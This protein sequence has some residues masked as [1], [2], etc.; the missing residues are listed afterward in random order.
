MEKAHQEF[1]RWAA[2]YDDGGLDTRS[3][4]K[5]DEWQK[6]LRCPLLTLRG[7]APMEENLAAIRARLAPERA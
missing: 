5:H 4:A 3:R 7:D 1:L 2:G 6:L